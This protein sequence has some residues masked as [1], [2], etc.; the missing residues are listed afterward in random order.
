MGTVAASSIV[1]LVGEFVFVKFLFIYSM[2][3]VKYF[4]IL[5]IGISLF[6]C[7]KDL[8]TPDEENA[9]IDKFISENGLSV[10][11]KTASGLRF[12]KTKTNASGAALAKGKSVALAYTGKLLSG[13]T[14]DSGTF[15]FYLGIGQVVKGFDEGVA[16]LRVG[17]KAILIFPSSLGYGADGAG[18]DIKGNT[19]LYFDVEVLSVL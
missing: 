13:K 17:E 9:Q 14:F 5:I 6:S 2:N 4:S 11:E 19:P 7:Q 10:S 15:S 16:K 8:L 3:L 12:I 1:D 18:K